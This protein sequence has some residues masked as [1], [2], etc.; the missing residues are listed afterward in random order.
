[1]TQH[2]QAVDVTCPAALVRYLEGRLGGVD[3]EEAISE[4]DRRLMEAAASAGEMDSELN[5]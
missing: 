5:G 2:R 3:Y 4:T 1:M